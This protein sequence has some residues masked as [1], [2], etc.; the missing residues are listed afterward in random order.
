MKKRVQQSIAVVLLTFGLSAPSQASVT[1]IAPEP[2]CAVVLLGAVVTGIVTADDGSEA[3]GPQAGR[4]GE[5]KRPDT[6]TTGNN[7]GTT[8]ANRIR[9]GAR[10]QPG[11]QGGEGGR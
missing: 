3:D 5:A 6:E 9:D 2:I 8:L 7:S 1:C 11:E 10:N 4:A